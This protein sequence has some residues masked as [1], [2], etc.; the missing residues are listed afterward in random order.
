M[1]LLGHI[2]VICEMD[3]IHLLQYC[4]IRWLKLQQDRHY[5]LYGGGLVFMYVQ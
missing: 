5:A 4:Y 3:G 2:T 1:P